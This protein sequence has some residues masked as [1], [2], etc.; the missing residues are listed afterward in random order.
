MEQRL[1]TLL[2]KIAGENLA[3]GLQSETGIHR[4]IIWDEFRRRYPDLTFDA[5]ETK[6]LN[7]IAALRG[8]GFIVQGGRMGKG[9]PYKILGWEPRKVKLIA[10]QWTGDRLETLQWFESLPEITRHLFEEHFPNGLCVHESSWEFV[11]SYELARDEGRL[12]TDDG[13]ACI[14]F[15]KFRDAPRFR[16]YNLT[17]S[18]QKLIPLVHRLNRVSGK[19]IRIY[20]LDER[21]VIRLHDF[22]RGDTARHYQAVYNLRQIAEFQHTF[23]S[24]S[25]FNS[26]KKLRR[27]LELQ[28]GTYSDAAK[29]VDLWRT[30]GEVKQRQLSITRDYRSF[31]RVLKNAL[32]YVGYRGDLPV[33]VV[34]AAPPLT[35]GGIP[36]LLTE[37]SLNYKTFPGGASGTSDWMTW[38]FAEELLRLGYTHLNTGAILGGTNGLRDHKRRYAERELISFAYE[39]RLI[40]EGEVY[41]NDPI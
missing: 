10:S 32:F 29:V 3:E 16:I 26:A 14:V 25:S 33:S 34:V 17:M 30:V 4:E 6:R 27:E 39:S 22:E 36:A 21:Q 38:A 8:E 2:E 15:R 18:A 37:K 24:K 31:D 11:Y 7:L 1:L 13:E 12:F 28:P 9:Q 41:E 5:I 35:E 23:L 40:P 20:H 19:K